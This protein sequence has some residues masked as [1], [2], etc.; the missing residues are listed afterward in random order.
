[1]K[2]FWLTILAI[3]LMTPMA[4]GQMLT[5]Q[6]KGSI[7]AEGVE[8]FSIDIDRGFTINIEGAETDSISYI[9]SFRGN[10]LTYN[11]RF[12][13]VEI[14]LKKS[15][16]E[17]RLHISIPK[18]T[19]YKG[20]G[21]FLERFFHRLFGGETYVF[22]IE[23]QSLTIKVPHRL[24]IESYTQYSDITMKEIEGDH[25]IENRSGTITIENGKG[26]VQIDNA[27]GDTDVR[28]LTGDLRIN[29]HSS[30]VRIEQIEGNVEIEGAYSDQIISGI[31]GNLALRNRSGELKVNDLSG[32]LDINSSYTETDLRR[33]YG[34]VAIQSQSGDVRMMEVEDNVTIN[35]SYIDIS[36]NDIDGKVRV[37]NR[38][39]ELKAKH[40]KGAIQFDGSYTDIKIGLY[41][42]HDLNIRNRSG[43]VSIQ[44]LQSLQHVS[45]SNRYEDVKISMAKEFSGQL[46]LKATYGTIQT[47]L[48][49]QLDGYNSEG[50]QEDH[51]QVVK[52]QVGSGG[53][54]EIEVEVDNGTIKLISES[55]ENDK[56]S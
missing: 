20:N 43:K 48:P 41:D 19:R 13:D 38:S 28:Y 55:H 49:I 52:G 14:D 24:A 17:A 16:E 6:Q 50:Q 1:M 39:G 23:E 2:R 34:E 35:G 45:I 26:S 21:N 25:K 54:N 51:I 3:C 18:V 8:K 36:M 27:Y 7:S 31:R 33:I 40:V 37:E 53:L 42:G 32:S 10:E 9:Y 47:N 4:V 11:Q 46:N 56:N 29:A 15:Q 22:E 44:A 12:K 5:G 30:D